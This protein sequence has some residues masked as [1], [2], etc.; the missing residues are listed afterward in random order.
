MLNIVDQTKSSTYKDVNPGGFDISYEDNSGSSGDYI[1][2]NFIIGGITIKNLEMG[3]ALNTTVSSGLMGIGYDTNEAATSI[4]PNIIDDMASQGLI[5]AKAYSLFLND[6]DASTGSIIFGGIDT[7]KF[8]GSLKALPIQPDQD[9]NGTSVFAEF[10]VAFTG[11][12]LTSSPNNSTTLTRPN[13]NEVVLLDSGTSI[14]YL[15]D[16]LAETVF[17]AVNAVDDTQQSGN[18]FVDCDLANQPGMSF[19][20]T[21]GGSQGPTISVP[22]SELVFNLTGI[23]ESDPSRDV[24][25]STACAFGIQPAAGG[26]NL[27]GDTFLRSAY[28]VYDLANNQVAL[29]Q[30]NFGS[31]E[32]NVVELSASQSSIPVLTG[33]A[34]DAQATPTATTL[35]PAKSGSSPG[36]PSSVV[37]GI[38]S[39]NGSG[40]G[41]STASTVATTAANAASSS[42]GSTAKSNA[43]VAA[44]YPAGWSGLMT[45]GISS[46]LAVC[47][48]VWLLA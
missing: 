10:N 25:F 27:F 37:G 48:G 43:G 39:G 16:Q 3:L 18:V 11:L 15:P 32:S 1:T 46:S 4:Y 20:F 26:P 17:Q 12:T 8:H 31:T 9:Q 28:V 35:S 47:G 41:S 29:A 23:F 14:T 38:E 24:P 5:Q 2:D 30:T 13:F 44:M 42:T 40:S 21:F 45:L 33:V 6:L 19:D 36:V 22:I 34:S 7:D